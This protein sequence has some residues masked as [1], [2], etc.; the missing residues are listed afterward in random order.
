INLEDN[1]LTVSVEK[2]QASEDQDKWIRKEYKFQSFKRSFSVDENI[3]VDAIE[4][5]YVNGVLVLN[6]PKKTVVK[7]A[8]KQIT[9]Q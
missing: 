1:M 4:A 9:I 5:K 8:A 3:N 7:E 6:L 2:E